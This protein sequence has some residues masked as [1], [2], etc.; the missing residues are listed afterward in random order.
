LASLPNG[1]LLGLQNN[2]DKDKVLIKGNNVT[3]LIVFQC[4]QD[5]D[6]T[7]VEIE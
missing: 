7:V 2:T 5:T 6:E 4:D 3:S 1:K